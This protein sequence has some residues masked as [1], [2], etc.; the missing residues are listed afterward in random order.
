M[1][2]A[3][4]EKV[5]S[6]GVTPPAGRQAEQKAEWTKNR[7]LCRGRWALA[8]D[9]KDVRRDVERTRGESLRERGKILVGHEGGGYAE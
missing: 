9:Q 7:G 4:L 3:Y 5:G 2:Q 1:A 6:L 8:S